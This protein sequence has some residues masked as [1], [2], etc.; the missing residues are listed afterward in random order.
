VV[1]DGL[2]KFPPLAIEC[3]LTGV[4][5]SLINDPKGKWT[6]SAKEWFELQTVDQQLTARVIKVHIIIFKNRIHLT[7]NVRNLCTQGFFILKSLNLM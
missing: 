5:P 7:A 6:K 3:Y 4:G 2:L 1:S